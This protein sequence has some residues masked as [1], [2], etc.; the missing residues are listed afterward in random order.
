MSGPGRY[1][2]TKGD[3]LDAISVLSRDHRR[4]LDLAQRFQGGL[5]AG[6][7]RAQLLEEMAEELATHA[8]IETEILF[9]AVQEEVAGAEDFAQRRI[10]EAEELRKKASRFRQLDRVSPRLE[11][12]A[13]RLIRDI[14]H[15]VEKEEDQVFALLT[16][17]LGDERLARLGADLD[18]ARRGTTR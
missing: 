16:Q 6:R 17:K 8:S 1:R 2:P 12:R 4:L 15:H 7:E 11:R 5:E 14:D 3:P 13:A 9:P 18:R 10:E